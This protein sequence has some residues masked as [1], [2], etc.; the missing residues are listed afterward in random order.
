MFEDRAEFVSEK[1][2]GLA[3]DYLQRQVD[4]AGEGM[5]GAN[6]S[7]C[8]V[9]E[10]APAGIGRPD[11]RAA[12][13]A[14]LKGR[15]LTV[16]AG[17]IDGADLVIRGDYHAVLQAAH[18]SYAD[19]AAR[20]RGLREAQHRNGGRPV[21]TMTGAGASGPAGRVFAGLHDHLAARTIENPDLDLR[22][23]R[24]GLADAARQL[25]EIGYAILE[26][27]V[28]ERFADELREAIVASAA[29]VGQAQC[30]MLLERGRIFEETALHPWL[31]ALG[32]KLCGRGFLL[33]QL[34]GLR[35]R[36]GPGEIGLHTDYVNVREP[37]PAQAQMCTA[38]WALEDFTAAAGSTWVVPATHH[39]KRHP[40]P[41]DDLSS[42][43][44][45]E[46]PKGS[47]AIWDGALWHWQ[48]GRELPGERVTLHTTYMQGTMRPY[49]DYLRIDPAILARNPP[50]LATL[51]AQ[52]DIFGK[53]THAGQQRQYFARSMTVRREAAARATEVA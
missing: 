25:D 24:L 39:L 22:I 32:E 21:A 27:A 53:N 42:A 14:R 11:G 34:L 17:E 47:I 23:A 19:E 4:A 6:F 52:D 18:V 3:R 41:S 51:A 1:W 30:G 16:G 37:F 5:D 35:K 13:H 33:G 38:I 36:Q 12:W 29:E 8:E 26:R 28:S 44:P 2:I 49:D 10:D 31:F 46:M 20:K 9:M 43:I 40:Q 15:Q 50:E 48:G 7:L 45:L